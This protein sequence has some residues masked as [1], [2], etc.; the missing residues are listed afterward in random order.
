MCR[1]SLSVTDANNIP[2]DVTGIPLNGVM[3][4]NFAALLSWAWCI[5]PDKVVAAFK[6]ATGMEISSDDLLSL[7]KVHAN[8][9]DVKQYNVNF[10]KV[11]MGIP[12]TPDEYKKSECKVKLVR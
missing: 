2:E 11:I 4:E 7:A 6:A 8:G 5:N 3:Q 9:N 12:F 10:N 1:C